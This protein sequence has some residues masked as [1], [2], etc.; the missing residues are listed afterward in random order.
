MT[1]VIVFINDASNRYYLYNAI[2]I[3]RIHILVF[4]IPKFIHTYLAQNNYSEKTA[5]ES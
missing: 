3:S 4:V 1:P 2:Q 5:F